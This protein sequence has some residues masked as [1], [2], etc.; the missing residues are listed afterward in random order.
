MAYFKGRQFRQ[1]AH[2]MVILVDQMVEKILCLQ[3]P[4]SN[5]QEVACEENQYLTTALENEASCE[6]LHR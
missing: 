3:E 6:D 4:F 1:S 5:R 2:K